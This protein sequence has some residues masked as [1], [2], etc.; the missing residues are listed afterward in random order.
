MEMTRRRLLRMNSNA[1]NP[2]E[3]ILWKSLRI[4]LNNAEMPLVMNAK[5][6]AHV[7]FLLLRTLIRD[8]PGMLHVFHKRYFDQVLKIV[9]IIKEHKEIA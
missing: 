9:K 8:F 6:M 1:W 5:K 4:A 2:Q 3:K 7:Y